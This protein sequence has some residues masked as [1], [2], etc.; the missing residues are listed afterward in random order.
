MRLASTA[1]GVEV[2]TDREAE[3]ATTKM[4]FVELCP[5][6]S[7][8]FTLSADVLSDLAQD[9]I[10]FQLAAQVRQ[11]LIDSAEPALIMVNGAA[12]LHCPPNSI[13]G[14][15]HEISELGGYDEVQI[16]HSGL[17]YFDR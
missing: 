16:E 4:I 14:K 10:G 1:L 8:R 6:P 5:Y 9:D 3:F 15:R 17:R 11:V 13:E 7:R 12:G 2:E